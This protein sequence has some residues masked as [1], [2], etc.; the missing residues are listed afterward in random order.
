MIHLLAT[1]G[2]GNSSSRL[3]S[4]AGNVEGGLEACLPSFCLT[5]GQGFAQEDNA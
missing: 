3:S 4:R 2:Q 1:E 5:H